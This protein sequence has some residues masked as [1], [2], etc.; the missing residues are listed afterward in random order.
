M[1]VQLIFFLVTGIWLVALT[2]VFYSFFGFFN[3]LVKGAKQAGLKKVLEEILEAQERNTSGIAALRKEIER[4]DLEG[5]RHVQKVGF[6]RFNPFKDIGGNNSFSLAIL[7]GS[8]SGVI[9]TS[10]HTRERTR[11]YMKA[12]KKGRCEY[13]LSDEEKKSLI[14]AQKG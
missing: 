8:G 14:L 7:D 10:L 1:Q 2:A 6:T 9:V 12:I 4:L 3:R 11:V 13:E 5:V